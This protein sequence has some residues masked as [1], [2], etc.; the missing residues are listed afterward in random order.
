MAITVNLWSRKTGEIKRFLE[1][2]YGKDV[3]MDED[4]DNWIYVY[5]KPVDAVDIISALI[6][7]ND[8]FQ[9]LIYI[10]VDEGDIHPITVENHNDVIKG[11]FYLFYE[12]QNE[13]RC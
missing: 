10:Q 9:I 1:K 5:N 6:D 8:R 2:Y 12:E 3:Y 13:I 7:N 4:V 11:I